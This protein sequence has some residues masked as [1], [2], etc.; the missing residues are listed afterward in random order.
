M[1]DVIKLVLISSLLAGV[2]GCSRKSPEKAFD[3]PRSDTANARA[4][5]DTRLRAAE[6]RVAAA[7]ARAE[8]PNPDAD[9]ETTSTLAASAVVNEKRTIPSR[10]LLTVLLIDG[11]GA[12]TK[13]EGD[14]FMASLAAPVVIDGKSLLATGTKV[15]GRVIGVED[16]GRVKGVVSIRLAL[17]DIMQGNRTIAI[18]TDTLTATAESLGKHDAGIVAGDAGV[19]AIIGIVTAGE[20]AAG[21]GTTSGGGAGTGVVVA[22]KGKEMRPEIRLSFTLAGPVQM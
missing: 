16:S 9:L 8:S 11:L 7:N 19:G 5:A 13:S 4:V 3:E 18:T 20:K 1:K 10:T 12:D 15:R 21:I 2:F 17:T 6:A 22:P 14:H